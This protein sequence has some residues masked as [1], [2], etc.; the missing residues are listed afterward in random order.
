MGEI[1]AST[2]LKFWTPNTLAVE[3]TTAMESLDLPI[4]Q[5]AEACHTCTALSRIKLRISASLV[6]LGSGRYSSPIVLFRGAQTSRVRL[7]VASA[8]STSAGR[9]SQFGLMT[10]ATLVSVL[11]TVTLPRKRGSTRAAA[12]EP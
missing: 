2:T 1:L 8:T 6:T 10:G 11:V 7:N 12:T 3:S 5:V 4:A 9:I